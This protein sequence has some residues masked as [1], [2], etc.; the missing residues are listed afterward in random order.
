MCA[1]AHCH[2]LLSRPTHQ[3]ERDEVFEACAEVRLLAQLLYL[4]EVRV[5]DVRVHSEEALEHGLHSVLRSRKSVGAQ[6]K[7]TCTPYNNTH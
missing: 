6:S 1:C 4:F 7:D 5:V 2:D 3:C